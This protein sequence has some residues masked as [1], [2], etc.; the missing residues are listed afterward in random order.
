M[1]GVCVY[2]CVCRGGRKEDQG[3]L[4]TGG[5]KSE[6]SSGWLRNFVSK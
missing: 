5:R 3:L 1:C 6:V 4:G 2:A